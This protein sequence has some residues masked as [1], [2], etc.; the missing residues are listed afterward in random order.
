M[1]VAEVRK[2][3]SETVARIVASIEYE[4]CDRPPLD[5]FYEA[6]RAFADWLHPNPDAF[7]VGAVL[8]AARNGE[9]RLSITGEVCP[10]L[11]EGIVTVLHWMGH[12]YGSK[13]QQLRIETRPRGSP[14]NSSPDRSTAL[15]LSGGVDS[16]ASLHVNRVHVPREHP[17]SIKEGIL[18]RG[19]N[20]S[21]H[22]NFEPGLASA[23]AVAS[24]VGITLVPI[25]TNVR[26]LDRNSEFWVAQ[27][28]GAALTSVA[29]TLIPRIQVVHLASSYDIPH[30]VPWGSHPALD[31]NYGSY[32]V[33]IRHD[34]VHM[35]RLAK[36]ALLA[37]WPLGLAHL[38]VC[39]GT[40]AI[41]Q[42][43]CGVCEKCVRTRIALLA[44]GLDGSGA[45]PP[46]ELPPSAIEEIRIR[47]E[48]AAVCFAEVIA[49][50]RRRGLQVHV[51]AVE[52][53]LKEYHR[54]RISAAERDWRGVIKKFDRRVFG[55]GLNRARSWMRAPGELG[56]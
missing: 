47:S 44:L 23:H 55:G 36:T 46:G 11:R 28:H 3:L 54:H 26:L 2:E 38:R 43:N 14:L 4:D 15:F 19:F 56:A 49:G 6:P 27:L 50:L 12:W 24:D 5:V 53:A 34:G 31:G 1:R 21:D 18:I 9:R 10:R 16:L 7:L 45:F 41:G 42:A 29:H 40:P 8:T 51:R 20:V 48:Y 22:E 52:M 32:E 13:W 39:T 37:A 17:A 25:T 35:S 30:L 33:A